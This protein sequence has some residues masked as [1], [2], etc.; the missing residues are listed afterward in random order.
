MNPWL[1]AAA[2]VAVALGRG[3]RRSSVPRGTL[4]GGT[5]LPRGRVTWR[6]SRDAFAK[7]TWEEIA[8][9]LP[10][11]PALQDAR[12]RSLAA[13]AVASLAARENG[14]GRFEKEHNVFNVHASSGPRFQVGRE[15]LR[16]Y[17][18]RRAAIRDALHSLT[19]PTSSFRP[20]WDRLVSE[21]DAGAAP[22]Q[23]AAEW[24]TRLFD[25][26]WGERPRDV[27]AFTEESRAIAGGMLA[28]LRREVATFPAAPSSAPSVPSS[29]PS[30]GADAGMDAGRDASMEE[31]LRAIEQ[32][33][34]EEREQLD[35]IRRNL[36]E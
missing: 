18:D 22:D 30:S 17:P 9:A 32:R 31:R 19:H 14:W 26:G 36:G 33:N 15:V 4:L 2:A 1:L 6:G 5:S 10:N 21:L 35:R 8:A 34:A 12:V 23:A 11:E 24:V 27:R 3:S 20:A 13:A 16:V 25:G 28:R 29:V 7:D